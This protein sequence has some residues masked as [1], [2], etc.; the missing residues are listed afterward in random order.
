[1]STEISEEMSCGSHYVIA[2]ADD[3][4]AHV[5]VLLK[6][7]E[8]S[9]CVVTLQKGDV[10]ESK[11]WRRVRNGEL[12]PGD[13]SLFHVKLKANS[14]LIVHCSQP[15][16]DVPEPTCSFTATFSL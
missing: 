5:T 8:D 14:D 11:T 9:D 2:T 1:M 12:Q 7:D 6:A 15:D 13:G 16:P 3:D 4:A 10:K